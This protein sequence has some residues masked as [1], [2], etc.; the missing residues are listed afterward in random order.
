MNIEF[1]ETA[2][3]IDIFNADIDLHQKKNL[4]FGN[5]FILDKILPS[6]A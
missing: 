3:V 5:I 1:N 6:A 4:F 2:N